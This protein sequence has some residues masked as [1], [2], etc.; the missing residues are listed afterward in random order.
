MSINDVYLRVK[1]LNN[2]LV[3]F[4]ILFALVIFSF[5]IF[6]GYEVFISDHNIYIPAIYKSMDPQLFSN[7]LLL[8]FNQTSYT[9]FDEFIVFLI[10]IFN[11]IIFYI[12]FFLTFLIRFIFYY[13]IYKITYYFTT[14]KLFS[15]L[16]VLLFLSGFLVYGADSSTMDIYLTPGAICISLSLL[17]LVF[18]F[19]NKILIS[20]FFLGLGLLIHPIT[21]IPFILFYYLDIVFNY[22]ENIK[23]KKLW[24]G[25]IIPFLFLILLLF[26]TESS[27][28][29]LFSFID[30]AW[31]NI[32]RYRTPQVYIASWGIMSLIHLVADLILIVII[33]IE[34]NKKFFKLEAKK[35]FYLL[36]IIPFFLFFLSFI[37]ADIFKLHLITQLQLA[38]SLLFWKILIIIIFS[39]YVYN[40]LK[41]NPKD[42]LYNLSLIGLIFS[43]FIKMKF[44][45]FFPMFFFL[46]LKKRYNLF[47]LVKYKIFN[48]NFFP[49]VIFFICTLG[50]YSVYTN[51]INVIILVAIILFALII[52]F[53]IWKK[54]LL[55][56]YNFLFIILFFLLVSFANGNYRFSIYPSYYSDKDLMESLVWIKKNTDKQDVFIDKPINKYGAQLRT[57]CQRNV[58]V[59]KKDGAQVV[60]NRDY[61]LEW[62]KRMELSEKYNK[63]ISYI[64]EILKDYRI[65]YI[66]SDKELKID[67]PLVFQNEKYYI[68]NIKSSI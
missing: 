59:T 29:K 11:L 32:I 17:F 42:F 12:F 43:F 30:S 26:F 66:F 52:N 18:Y 54:S 67:I 8:S 7:D 13:A 27:G 24:I 21:S 50:V 45:V 19:N 34:L 25:A 31:E 39:Y 51:K 56:I 36:L 23:N 4:L 28:L 49:Y 40:Y 60:F 6:P 63:D 48:S 33:L 37:G 1:N 46:W 35:Y 22:K 53:I 14:N 5:L 47:G 68:Y 62:K 57:V 16:S 2:N 15:I 65:D 55:S 38:R 41:K 58:F 44:F 3:L 20:S 61:A 64:K 9:L 10:K